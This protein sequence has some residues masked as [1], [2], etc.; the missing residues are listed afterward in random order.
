MELQSRCWDWMKQ[1]IENAWTAIL[2]LGCMS[3]FW[4]FCNYASWSYIQ[5]LVNNPSLRRRVKQVIGIILEKITFSANVKLYWERKNKKT[6][7]QKKK[8]VLFCCSVVS[9]SLWPM[10]CSTPGFP[11]LP[12]LLEFSQIH[13]HC[14]TSVLKW[15]TK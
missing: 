13:V 5:G 14:K 10:N 11:V 9:E 1:P 8:L 15:V 3:V 7:K 12:Y 2:K 4:S 6:K